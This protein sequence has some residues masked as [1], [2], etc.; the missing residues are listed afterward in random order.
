MTKNSPNDSAAEDWF[1]KNRWG[2][3]VTCPSCQSTRVHERKTC[4]KSW[5]CRE[6][7]KDVSV[8]TATL[9]ESSNL[10]FRTWAIAI[11]LLTTSKKGISRA[12]A[13]QE[14]LG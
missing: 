5:R 8:K 7:R 14:K 3:G 1:I 12:D 11:E 10:G 4:K 6:C 13:P 9:M 2:G